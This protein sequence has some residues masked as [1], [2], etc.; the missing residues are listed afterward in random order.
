MPQQNE[1]ALPPDPNEAQPPSTQAST[2]PPPGK[3]APNESVPAEQG[4][5]GLRGAGLKYA[6][7][8]ASIPEWARGKTA[9]EILKAAQT[10]R[11]AALAVP[12][13]PAAPPPQKP[14]T[15]EMTTQNTQP[16]PP[17]PQ[18]MY[19]EPARY[20]QEMLAYQNAQLAA[21]MQ[22]FAAPMIQ[23]QA[24]FAKAEARR[25][26][27]LPMVWD[28]YAS[29]IEAQ[30]QNVPVQARTQEAWEMAAKLVAADHM[31]EIAQARA[32]TLAAR[33]DTG[34]VGADGNMPAGS[35]IASDPL[36]QLFLDND[37]AVARLKS[38]GKNAD[39][40][41]RAAS[42]MGLTVEQY[43]EM[44][45]KSSVVVHSTSGTPQTITETQHAAAVQA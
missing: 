35:R 33:A 42:A 38:I 37:P 32:E 34:T 11:D 21:Q 7:D 23:Q 1:T 26:A 45:K 20:Q 10:Y 41:K 4:T 5:K 19:S 39:D 18:L 36:T 27:K 14:A 2:A 16:Q 3:P 13:A 44:L 6:S 28:K 22:S 12:V 31:D 43:A 30:M 9:D 25:A 15:Y 8:D 24:A 17:D 29:E 40:A